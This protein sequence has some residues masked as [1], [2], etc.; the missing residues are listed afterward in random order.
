M[1]PYDFYV[2]KTEDSEVYIFKYLNEAEDFIFWWTD[3]MDMPYNES[4]IKGH[5]FGESIR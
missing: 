1:T 4:M 2:V 5:M 3:Q